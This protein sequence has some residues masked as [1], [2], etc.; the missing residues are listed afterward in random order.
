ME[1]LVYI[2]LYFLDDYF[3]NDEDIKEVDLINLKKTAI[4]KGTS[5]LILKVQEYLDLLKDSVADLPLLLKTKFMEII[6]S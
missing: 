1:S 5:P 6:A 3:L 4:M 2:A